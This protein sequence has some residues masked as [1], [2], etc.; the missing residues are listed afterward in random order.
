MPVNFDRDTNKDPSTRTPTH[1]C[2]PATRAPGARYTHGTDHDGIIVGLRPCG[3][4]AGV[5]PGVHGARNLLE[6]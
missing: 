6:G 3:V 1:T 5:A 2:E 4:C